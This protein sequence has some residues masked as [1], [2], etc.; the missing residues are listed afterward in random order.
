MFDIHKYDK[1][2]FNKNK[3]INDK[4]KALYLLFDKHVADSKLNY[5]QSQRL[6]NIWILKFISYEEYEMA[7][8]FKQRKI[9]MW[10]DWRKIHRLTSV[11]LF[12]RVWRIR[13]K[14]LFK[15]CRKYFFI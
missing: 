1:H 5:F 6:I 11:R 9:Q 15:F 13:L 4:I 3:A 12:W 10:R 8:A 7:E 14:K 2:K